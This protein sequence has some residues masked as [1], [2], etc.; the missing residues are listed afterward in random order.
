MKEFFKNLNFGTGG[1][2]GIMGKG[3]NCI[4]QDTVSM[5]TIGLIQYLKKQYANA[6]ISVVI[7]YDV[8][9]NSDLFAHTVADLCSS[10]QIKVYL[11]NS[12]RPTPELAYTVCKLKCQAGIMI[13]ASHNPPEYNGYKIYNHDGSQIVYPTDHLIMNEIQNINIKNY[14]Y[15]KNNPNLIDLIGDEID[16]HFIT[17]CIKYTSFHLKGKELL[18]IV[19]TP[20]HG[21]SIHIVPKALYQAGFKNIFIVKE[22]SIPDHK[23]STVQSPNPEEAESFTMALSLANFHQADIILASD[24]DGDRLGVAVRDEIG[25]MILLN[26]NQVN[27]LLVYYILKYKKEQGLL[28]SDSFIISTLVSSDIFFKIANIFNIKC[29]VSLTG[30]KWIAKLIKDSKQKEHF[31]CGG[32]ESFGFMIGNF[33]LD[34]DAITSLLLISEI[35]AYL[36]HQGSSLYKELLYIYTQTGYFQDFLYSLQEE[37]YVLIALKR[38]K[39]IRVNP[40]IMIGKTKIIYIEDYENQIQ[41]NLINQKKRQLNF[42][43]SNLLIFRTEDNTKIAIRP[44]GTEPKIKF[45]ISVNMPIVKQTNYSLIKNIMNK[46]IHTI[47]LELKKILFYSKF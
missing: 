1:I 37:K 28:H 15:K 16:N 2:R 32:E 20:L 11:F 36:K 24:P 44:S 8:R 14:I 38:I 35:A 5:I 9:K 26:G 27:T 33:L 10:E 7:A 39:E 19:F 47:L 23:F 42:P 45:Y 17:D 13:T 22:Q 3:Y 25:T 34:K 43:I 41:V 6:N 21:T 29:K 31:I 46:K 40:P 12:F 30:F 4:N 18:N